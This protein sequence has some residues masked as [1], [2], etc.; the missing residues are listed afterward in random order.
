MI[1]SVSETA[2][3]KPAAPA[4]PAKTKGDGGFA[5][6]LAKADEKTA[7]KT[8]KPA[9]KAVKGEK[10]DPVE[11]HLYAEVTAGPRNGMFINTSGNERDGKAFLVVEREG[12]TFHVYGTGA[13]RAVFEIKDPVPAATAPGS[14]TGTPGVAPT[15]ASSAPAP[16]VTPTPPLTT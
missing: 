6:E 15:P 4:A 14:K 3:V 8:A 1:R 9:A 10:T 2:P 13:N 7:A 12:R 16:G 11:G 5:A